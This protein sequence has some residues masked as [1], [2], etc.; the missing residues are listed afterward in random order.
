W[1]TRDGHAAA[2]AASSAAILAVGTRTLYGPGPVEIAAQV[3]SVW[4]EIENTV[5]AGGA[6]AHSLDLDHQKGGAEAL[7]WIIGDHDRIAGLGVESVEMAVPGGAN[8]HGG[9]QQQHVGP[10]QA[11]VEAK[12]AVAHMVAQ[13][14]LQIAKRRRP[15]WQRVRI[16]RIESAIEIKGYGH[17]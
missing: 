16:G 12:S 7:Y 2:T 17:R 1:T 3:V 8:V 5:A 15:V 13:L 4:C 11:C 9:W 14:A 6:R 10:V